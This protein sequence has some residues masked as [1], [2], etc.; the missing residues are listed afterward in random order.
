M[1]QSFTL[2]TTTMHN[3][4]A[5][6]IRWVSLNE[7]A[8]TLKCHRNTVHRWAKRGWITAKRL[9]SGHGPWVILLD[10]NNHTIDPPRPVTK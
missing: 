5:P 1:R 8:F 2:L 10:R 3:A 4:S 6:E 7:A 9:A